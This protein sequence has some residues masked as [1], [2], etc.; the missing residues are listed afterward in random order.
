MKLK[1]PHSGMAGRGGKESSNVDKSGQSLGGVFIRMEQL[2]SCVSDIDKKWTH[3]NANKAA[4]DGIK[5]V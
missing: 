3:Y 4:F 5:T 2:K 1:D